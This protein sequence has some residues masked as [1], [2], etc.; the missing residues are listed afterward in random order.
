MIQLSPRPAMSPRLSSL[1]SPL[2]L[3][4]DLDRADLDSATPSSDPVRVHTWMSVHVGG[5]HA[6]CTTDGC[7]KWGGGSLLSSCLA[8][9]SLP[10]MSPSSLRIWVM[11][12]SSIRRHF[13]ATQ[14]SQCLSKKD[15]ARCMP[16]KRGRPH[17]RV[18]LSTW[19]S[20]R[21]RR[22]SFHFREC[23][24]R[25]CCCGRIPAATSSLRVGS[26]GRLPRPLMFAA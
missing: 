1:L 24:R 7:R 15:W 14:D 25:R 2:P 6:P 11:K 4:S 8:P 16:G 3:R 10:E 13:R 19:N 22:L 17:P 23:G 12:A 18:R 20:A 5:I 9:V 21:R 26:K